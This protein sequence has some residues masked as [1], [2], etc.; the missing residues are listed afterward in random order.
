V[1]CE[2]LHGA[3]HELRNLARGIHPAVLSQSGLRPALEAVTGSL[4]LE[5]ELDVP[6][7]RFE[8]GLETSAYYTV[9]E[10]LTNAVK[11]ADATSA[12]V[13]VRHDDGITRIEVIDD[14]RG[15]AAAS[16]DGGLAGLTDRLR[17]M[18]GDLEIISPPGGG[19]RL[20][21]IIPC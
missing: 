11:H 18:D 16:E 1:A 3:L 12:R 15:G 21:A 19:T 7:S 17:A 4:P 2:D 13:V 14:G 5:V 20:I 9:C 8:P 6:P 10:G